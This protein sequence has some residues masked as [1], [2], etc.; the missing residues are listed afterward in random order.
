MSCVCITRGWRSRNHAGVGLFRCP[1]ALS[2]RVGG[3]RVIVSG[4]PRGVGCV[5][6][7]VAVAGGVSMAAYKAAG[8]VYGRRRCLRLS[9]G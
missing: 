7:V 9:Y 6:V 2:V 8:D 5:L 3:R 1:D 4:W